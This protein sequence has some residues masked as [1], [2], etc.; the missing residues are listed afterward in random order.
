VPLLEADTTNRTP[1]T[2]SCDV[3]D[4]IP[5]KFARVPQLFKRRIVRYAVVGAFGLP[6][7]NLAL[8]LFLFITGG[9]YWLALPLAFEISSTVNFVLNQ[10]FTYSE[11]THLRG[12]DWPKR[13]FR[14]QL[15][16][17]SAIMLTLA[18]AFALKYGAHVNTYLATD[19][20]IIMA[21][22]YNFLISRRLVFRPQT[23]ETPL[24]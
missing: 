15:T 21:F 9:I 3:T 16:S 24:I 20:G 14:A 10:R 23:E 5:V 19:I 2:V 7:N 17:G 6:V 13:A 4:S 8:A 22:F 11:Q 1:R 18:V 12:W